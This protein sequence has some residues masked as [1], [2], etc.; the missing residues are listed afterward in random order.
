MRTRGFTLTDK[1][2]VELKQ[3]EQ[4]AKRPDDLRRMQAVRLFGTGMDKAQISDITGYSERNLQRL[5]V[6]YRQDGITGLYDQRKGGN[7]TRLSAEQRRELEQR[8][9][10]YRPVDLQVSAHEYWTV[11][12]LKIGVERW[13]GVVYQSLESYYTLLHQSGFSLQRP[14]KV[15]RSRPNER[16]MADFEAALEKN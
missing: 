2:V 4:Q 16:A 15:Y 14:A 13:F 1:E 9:H 7:R 3:A 8:L 6:C 10:Q 11:S 5:A 12:D